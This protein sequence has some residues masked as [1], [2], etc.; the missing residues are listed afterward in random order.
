[1]RV[2]KGKAVSG[3]YALGKI[4]RIDH[5]I[6]NVSRTVQGPLR[7]RALFDAAVVIAKNELEE[8]EQRATGEQK[9]ILLF[10]RLL[11]DDEVLVNAVGDFIRS[12]TGSAEAV[13]RA[14]ELFAR[15][16]QQVDDSYIADRSTDVL[17]VCRRV[18]S[19]LDGKPRERLNLTEPMILASETLYPSDIFSA[20]SGMI[21]GI[22]TVEGSAQSHAALVAQTLGIPA[23][24]KV[25]SE[26][27]ENCDDMPA[28]LDGEKGELILEPD[29]ACRAR[30]LE[31]KDACS[32]HTADW[33]QLLAAPCRTADGVPFSL[34]GNCSGPE[35]IEAAVA[36]GAQEVGLLRTEFALAGSRIPP[37]E[38]Q[39]YFYVSCLAAAGGRPVTIRTYDIGA[40]KFSD[41]VSFKPGPNPALGLRGLRLCLQR[42]D[43]FLPQIYALLRAGARGELRVMFPMVGDVSEWDEAMELVETAR[44]NLRKRSVTFK[45]DLVFGCMIEVPGAALTARELAAHGCKFFSIGTNDLAQY[46]CAA[47]R[48]DPAVEKYF[49]TDS[50]GVDRL[51]QMTVDAAREANIP[52]CVCGMAAGQPRMAEHYLR[53]GVDRLSMASQCLMDVKRHLT[54]ADLHHPEQLPC[55]RR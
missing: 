19:I 24:I 32:R 33:E 34:L 3:G 7:E 55:G 13:E 39:F 31:Q 1:M 5:G 8:L 41:G 36:C 2:F 38:E 50:L 35:D 9:D 30:I 29:E 25:E 52:V 47:D 18:V 10:Q 14:S 43:I 11:L 20:G 54:R 16:L 48:M 27:L 15:R 28:A 45:E 37:E 53:L 26:F 6:G 21:L 4:R 49:R 23:L 40:D 42:Q 44:E 51:V 46:T 17:D 12:G 22:V